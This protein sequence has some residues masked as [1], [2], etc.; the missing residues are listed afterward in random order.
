MEVRE[1]GE[2]CLAAFSKCTAC[3]RAMKDVAAEVDAYLQLLRE[4]SGDCIT[5][6]NPPGLGESLPGQNVGERAGIEVISVLDDDSDDELTIVAT[7]GNN[8]LADF[9]HSRKFVR[10]SRLPPVAAITLCTAPNATVMC[11][12]SSCPSARLG[13]FTDMRPTQS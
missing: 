9:S 13:I 11:V 7:K 10:P 2:D 3:T 8:A 6:E 5:A 4:G 12:T 1:G